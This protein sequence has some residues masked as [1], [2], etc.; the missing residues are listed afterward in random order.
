[1]LHQLLRSL[2][3]SIRMYHTY[4]KKGNSVI[5]SLKCGV[6]AACISNTTFT[7]IGHRGKPGGLAHLQEGQVGGVNITYRPD[8]FATMVPRVTQTLPIKQAHGR[9]CFGNES[10]G[11]EAECPGIHEK[12]PLPSR[13]GWCRGWQPKCWLPRSV[14]SH[15]SSHSRVPVQVR[16]NGSGSG[17][18][19][20]VQ[21]GAYSSNPPKDSRSTR[22]LD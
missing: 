13:E 9:L 11:K 18:V 22:P 17:A 6:M 2:Y 8:S 21:P 7:E 20:G 4:A 10:W 15:G 3:K 1:M 16:G 5:V 14:A 19:L 12:Q